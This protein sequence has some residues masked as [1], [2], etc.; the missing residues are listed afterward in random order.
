M[1]RFAECRRC[2]ARSWTRLFKASPGVPVFL[3]PHLP[4]R[5]R[6]E[7]PDCLIS[8][9]SVGEDDVLHF[10]VALEQPDGAA[11]EGL[12]EG[13]EDHVGR[14][15]A[16]HLRHVF[17]QDLPVY[18]L[19]A[20]EILFAEPGAMALVEGLDD[21]RQGAPF[22][23]RRGLGAELGDRPERLRQVMSVER[24]SGRPPKASFCT[25]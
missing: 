8:C 3:L 5:P 20:Q 10:V 22:V 19:E 14:V 23:F 9:F 15:V 1:I 7:V 2:L 4:Q 12:R 6:E 21:L 24:S 16:E 11:E 17:V 18:L 13:G 25:S